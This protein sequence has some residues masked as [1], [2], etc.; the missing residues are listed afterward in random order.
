M[1]LFTLVS[2]AATWST[3]H[4]SI[5]LVSLRSPDTHTV[6]LSVYPFNLVISYVESVAKPST[7][8]TG[9][10]L[11]IRDV[12]MLSIQN[13]QREKRFGME[14]ILKECLKNPRN[15]WSHLLGLMRRQFNIS[16]MS[17]I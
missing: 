8:T 17:I 4:V 11:V 16:A 2:L 1:I 14:K 15:I 9:N 7:S 12:I 13:V 10:T 6:S 5:Y 3:D